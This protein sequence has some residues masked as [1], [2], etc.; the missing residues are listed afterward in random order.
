MAISLARVPWII[1]DLGKAVDLVDRIVLIEQGSNRDER[2]ERSSDRLLVL[3]TS[4]VC[5]ITSAKHRT[6]LNQRVR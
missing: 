1:H 6:D 4:E 2:S 5:S 3:D